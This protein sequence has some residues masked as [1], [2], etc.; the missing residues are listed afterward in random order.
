M[1]LKI[2]KK[3]AGNFVSEAFIEKAVMAPATFLMSLLSLPLA[4]S[5]KP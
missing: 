4:I 1:K 5:K 2:N 3:T